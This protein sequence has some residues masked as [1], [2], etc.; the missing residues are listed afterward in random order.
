M[1]LHGSLAENLKAAI[2]SA[3][4]LNG[5]PLHK[6]TLQFWRDL[7][8]HARGERRQYSARNLTTTDQLICELE[9]LLIRRL[10]AGDRF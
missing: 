2:V 6:D 9:E 7:L 4:R 8:Q 1:E 10:S 5:H 3:R